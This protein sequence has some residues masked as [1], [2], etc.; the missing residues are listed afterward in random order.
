MAFAAS[1][2]RPGRC[3][4]IGCGAARNSLPLAALGFE[5]TGIDL[6]APMIAAAGE[7]KLVEGPTLSV[8]FILAAAGFEPLPATTLAEYNRPADAESYN[9]DAPTIY[10]GY[11]RKHNA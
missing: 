10:E 1:L 4:D 8:D 7:R 9:D 5:V 6:S 2:P 3:L 11:F